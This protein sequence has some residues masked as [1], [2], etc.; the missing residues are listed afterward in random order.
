VKFT[1]SVA[2]C[3]PAQLA[4]L[5]RVAQ[6]CGYDAIA[7]P[8]SIFFPE[9]AAA[10]YPYTPDG[11]RFWTE[12]T[13]WFDPL[14]AAA[15]MAQVTTTIRFYTSVL[16]LGPRSPLLLARQVGTVAHL[17]G[18]RFG[19]GVGIGWSPE[20]SE[21]CGAPFSHRGARM[22]EAIDVI[23]LVLGGG[24][25]EYHGKFYDFDRLAMSPAPTEPVPIYIG[26]H[27][28]AALRR[29]ARF[30]GWS[31]AMMTLDELK[32]TIDRLRPEV[33]D[34]P[35]EYQA[36]CIDRFGPD[37]YREQEDIGVTDAIVAP[38]FFYQDLS[39]PDAVR[40]FAE[41]VMSR[42]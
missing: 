5:A 11:S 1:L 24:F 22:D 9:H 12:E 16:K 14:I 41:E 34:R 27:T 23:K 2:M 40:R 4:E 28:D 20:E 26:G 42:V 31:S 30:D 18:D 21:W 39:T 35:F 8:D 6:E 15:A 25:V 7:L 13:P 17:T 10:A 36:V 38:G 29:A 19:L 3:H 33:G 32:Q 37:G